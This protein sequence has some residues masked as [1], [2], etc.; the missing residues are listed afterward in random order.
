VEIG[1]LG[2][3]TR[4]NQHL[5]RFN[6]VRFGTKAVDP[7][8][9]ADKHFAADLPAVQLCRWVRWGCPLMLGAERI[10]FIACHAGTIGRY[11]GPCKCARIWRRGQTH[12]A[13]NKWT[14]PPLAGSHRGMK[15][16]AHIICCIISC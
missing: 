6:A 15:R 11:R 16:T 1:G 2:C 13:R 3:G 12:A 9:E 10:D 5:G 7:V 14:D 8:T 4:I